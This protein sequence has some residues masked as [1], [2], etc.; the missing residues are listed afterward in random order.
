MLKTSRNSARIL[1]VAALLFAIGGVLLRTWML[2][3]AYLP[4]DGFYTDTYL[5]SILRYALISFTLFAFAWAHIY[6]KEGKCSDPL[7]ESKT[8]AAISTALGC[9][10][11]GFLIYTLARILLPTLET[12][13][14]VNLL[15]CVF[16]AASLLFYFS[17]GKQSDVRALFCLSP[18]LVL[19]VMI[20][21]LYFNGSVSYINHTIVL[22]FAAAIF[23]MLATA[24]E[25]NILLGRPAYR[26]YL[27]YAPVAIA[28]CFTLSVPDIL[29]WMTDRVIAVT[30]IYYDILFFALG[31]YHAAR[32][33]LIALAPVKEEA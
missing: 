14:P 32:L 16:A 1:G 8:F 6:I 20:F 24:A 10:M 4:E 2:Q 12:P 7:P 21:G 26:R 5:H 9:V 18:A 27:S 22:C 28:L 29:Y 11:S 17:H 13:A 19:L 31:V 23:T 30:D 15:M 33:L 3:N 25:A